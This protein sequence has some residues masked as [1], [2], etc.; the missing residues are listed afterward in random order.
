MTE[1]PGFQARRIIRAAAFATLATQEDG[2]PHAGLVTPAA[3]PDL[4]ILLWL[5]DL[6]EH[7][8]Q[9]K[10]EPRCA[11]L[12]QG[13]AAEANPQTM[14]RVTVTGTA[15]RIEDEALKARW[16][17]RHPYAALYA[18]FGDFGLWRV[19]PAEARLVGGFARAIRLPLA[20]LLPDHAAL[21]SVSAAEAGIIAH[22]NDEHADAISA[23]AEG[24]LGE[25][26][27]A[28]RIS[29][30]DPDGIDL[31][32]GE[33]VRRWA[34]FTPAASPEDVRM[35]L[36]RGAREGRLHKSAPQQ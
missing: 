21:A 24:L 9:L 28:W 29:A 19:V 22:V 6:S 26:T 13:E 7:T 8:R 20:K 35:N 31:I 10:R 36:I 25:A 30:L 17:A 34:F 27:G 14:P 12:F 2:Q 15:E 4:S 18:G 23:I 16:L 11:L 33:I 3:A 1:D 32:S 5:S